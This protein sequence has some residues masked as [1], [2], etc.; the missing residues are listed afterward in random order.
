MS[1]CDIFP[2]DPS[3]ATP[4][5]EPEPEEPEEEEPIEDDT[6]NEVEDEDEGD[7]GEEDLDQEAAK[8]VKGESWLARAYTL[9]K[10][11]KMADRDPFMAQIAYLMTAGGV[12]MNLSLHM[13]KWTS[14]TDAKNSY[15]K[16]EMKSGDTNWW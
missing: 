3:C 1:L 16:G 6:T 7:A 15:K 13:F 5:P 9:R 4:E 2:D 8:E 10:L 14:S 11:R 12:A